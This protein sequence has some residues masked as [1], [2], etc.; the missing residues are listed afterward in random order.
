MLYEKQ[1][2][3]CSGEVSA[4]VV[5]ERQLSFCSTTCCDRY[6]G[7][8]YKRALAD[9]VKVCGKARTGSVAHMAWL[10]AVQALERNEHVS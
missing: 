7:Y 10:V 6:F 1:C 2:G 8:D 5:V 4:V 9:V 3:W